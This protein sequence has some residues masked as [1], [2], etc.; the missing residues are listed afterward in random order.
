MSKSSGQQPTA[1]RGRRQ[2]EANATHQCP[3]A[4]SR[5]EGCDRVVFDWPWVSPKPYPLR[6]RQ[7][8]LHRCILVRSSFLVLFRCCFRGCPCCCRCRVR[9]GCLDQL[10]CT[11]QGCNRF[12]LRG[13]RN[14]RRY[15][16]RVVTNISMEIIVW[17][18]R[19]R[20]PPKGHQAL[21]ILCYGSF[22][23]PYSLFEVKSCWLCR[24]NG[25]GNCCVSIF[26]GNGEDNCYAGRLF[27]SGYY[28]SVDQHPYH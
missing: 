9:C 17:P 5:Q 6:F 24:G 16:E 22:K 21:V 4:D 8:N 1:S 18:V 20:Q 23:T 7:R 2:K 15:A 28:F 27:L 11:V 12:R 14:V 19:I 10:R 13:V 3:R 26:F 25:K